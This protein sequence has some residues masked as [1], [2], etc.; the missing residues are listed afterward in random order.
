M[1]PLH[2]LPDR[3]T[4]LGL[5]TTQDLQALFDV[6]DDT[7]TRAVKRGDLPP[8]VMLFGRHVWSLE[9]IQAHLYDRL[10]HAK[11]AAAREQAKQDAK[12]LSLYGGASYGRRP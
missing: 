6:T 10:A 9:G 2:A 12:L 5:A 7:I 3:L 4:L 1:A 11:E 8:P